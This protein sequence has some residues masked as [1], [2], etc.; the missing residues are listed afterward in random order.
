[1]NKKTLGH[2]IGVLLFWLGCSLHFGS[3]FWLIWKPI[4]VFIPDWFSYPIIGGLVV[5]FIGL[6][7][8]ITITWLPIGSGIEHLLPQKTSPS[9]G[10]DNTKEKQDP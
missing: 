6:L 7:I 9:G 2:N 5:C 1:M 8:S 10:V 3:L 4:D